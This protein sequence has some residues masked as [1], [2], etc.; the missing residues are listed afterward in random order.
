LSEPSGAGPVG[1]AEWFAGRP[2]ECPGGRLASAGPDVLQTILGDNSVDVVG[3]ASA[4]DAE[5]LE[6][7][8]ETV[9]VRARLT[10]RERLSRI[11]PGEVVFIVAEGTVHLAPAL[12]LLALL[13]RASLELGE[14]SPHQETENEDTHSG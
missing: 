5:R 13:L 4:G 11:L 1:E 7:I 12:P 3:F 14:A 6:A 10:T 2:R 8:A 9:A